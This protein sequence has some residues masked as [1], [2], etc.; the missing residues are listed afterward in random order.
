MHRRPAPFSK[1]PACLL[2]SKLLLVFTPSG[3]LFF[4]LLALGTLVVGA[5]SLIVAILAYREQERKDRR[6]R[7]RKKPPTC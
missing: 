3:S 2:L 6:K 7:R 4:D 5:G 1:V